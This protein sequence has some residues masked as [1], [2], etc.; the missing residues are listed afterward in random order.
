[1]ETKIKVEGTLLEKMRKIKEEKYPHI[2]PWSTF[3]LEMARR[4]LEQEEKK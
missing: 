4:G 1:M 3:I 2:K